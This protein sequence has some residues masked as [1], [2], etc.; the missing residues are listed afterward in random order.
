MTRVAVVGCGAWGR[1]LIRTCA[2]LGVLGAVIDTD[3]EA[4]Q[5]QADA[6]NVPAVQLAQALDDARLDAMIIAAPAPAHA[7]LCRLALDHGKDVFVEKPLASDLAEAEALA[8]D[9]ARSDRVFM[10][11][12]LLRHHPAFQ[13]LAAIVARGEIG[14]LRYITASRLSL[15]RVRTH[16][17]AFLSLSP[18]DVSMILA[19]ADAAPVSVEA[20]GR[21]FVT[22]GVA[23]EVHADLCFSGGLHAHIAASWLSPV[24]EQ[25]LVVVGETGAL[26]FDDVRPWPEKLMRRDQ[27]VTLTDAGP[28][29]SGAEPRFVDLVAE[30]PLTREIRHFIQSCQTRETPLTGIDEGI[31]VQRALEH[32]QLKLNRCLDQLGR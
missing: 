22:P 27:G 12:H 31:R 18:H 14:A 32:V 19:L 5:D 6:W 3:A 4:A 17:N 28:T 26:V 2:E 15:G 1:N 16:E 30:P 20:T 25:K 24:K 11:G 21:A 9:V 13:A 23:D 29:A 8:A 7:A 10:V